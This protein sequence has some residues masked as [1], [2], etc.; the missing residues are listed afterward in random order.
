MGQP[1]FPFALR[2]GYS[3]MVVWT[4]QVGLRAGRSQSREVSGLY[5]KLRKVRFILQTF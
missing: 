3:R 5:T 2:V 1:V 4:G